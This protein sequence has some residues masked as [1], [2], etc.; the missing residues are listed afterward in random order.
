M[1]DWTLKQQWVLNGQVVPLEADKG[2][3]DDIW[4]LTETGSVE[5]VDL[6]S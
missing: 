3:I 6:F 4:N 2:D 5:C 1:A